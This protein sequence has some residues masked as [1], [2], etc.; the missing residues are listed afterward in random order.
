VRRTTLESW[1]GESVSIACGIGRGR[2][3]G[4]DS[5]KRA[6]EPLGF[7][8]FLE[9]SSRIGTAQVLMQ[10]ELT[11]SESFDGIDRHDA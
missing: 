8:E 3:R 7:A 9:W 1:S 11:L 10:L 4:T 6:E 2:A 5:P